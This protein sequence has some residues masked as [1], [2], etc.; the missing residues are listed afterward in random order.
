MV[1]KREI[2][3]QE[4]KKE[5]QRPTVSSIFFLL[6][7]F[8]CQ[9]KFLSVTIQCYLYNDN[10]NV[11]YEYFDYIDESHGIKQ[12]T[13]TSDYDFGPFKEHIKAEWE[14]AQKNQCT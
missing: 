12:F 7:S 11:H 6:L 9:K 1:S 10:D 5:S 3:H 13:P 4:K 8:R 2:T 14:N